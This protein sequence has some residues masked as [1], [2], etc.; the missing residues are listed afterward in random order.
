MEQKIIRTATGQEFREA[1][2]GVSTI[3]GVLRIAILD[4]DADEVHNTFR[5]PA[6]TATLTRI[7]D[8]I[9]S[10]YTGFT[11]YRGYIENMNGEI[12]V[13]LSEG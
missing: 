6:E 8:G 11:K 9:E 10:V 2:D 4:A 7:W 1:W 5:D 12:I 3:D 13:S